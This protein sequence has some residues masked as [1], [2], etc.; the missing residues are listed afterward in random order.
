MTEE[1]NINSNASVQKVVRTPKLKKRPSKKKTVQVTQKIEDFPEGVYP[2]NQI[3]ADVVYADP[4]WMTNQVGKYGACQHYHLM[5]LEDI[6]A[7]PVA[8]LCKENAACFLWVPNSILQEGLDVLKAWGFSYRSLFNWVKA[9]MGLG[10]YFRNASESLLFGIKGKMPVDFKAQPNWE[11][12]PR[13]EHSRKPEE[14]YAIIERMYRNRDYIELFAR[15]RPSNQKWFIWGDEAEGGSDIY[16][17]GYPVP[18]YSGRVLF[19]KADDEPR[20]SAPYSNEETDPYA[21]EDADIF[22]DEDMREAV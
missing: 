9:Q 11:F 12:L 5:K 18:E 2:L 6:K 19:A 7:M 4:P 22:T 15:K 8:D 13:Q 1:K 10:Q 20:D 21:G 17:P 16:I 14:M 3:K